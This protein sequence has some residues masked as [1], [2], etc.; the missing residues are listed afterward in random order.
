MPDISENEHLSVVTCGRVVSGKS[1]TTGRLLCEVGGIPERELDKLKQEAEHLEK[2]SFAH[3]FYMD[4]QKEGWERGGDIACTTKEFFTD[5][6]HY[7][8]I[9]APG[10][11]YSIKST[12]AGGS[13]ADVGDT[14]V[15][16]GGKFNH[17]AEEI[18]RQTRKHS[19]FIDLHWREQDGEHAGMV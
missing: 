5:K 17:K 8:I 13:Q 11:R 3:I 16:A 14:M 2:S 12:I 1:N 4:R 15:S 19:R 18:Q 10:N 9:G 6:W 7:V